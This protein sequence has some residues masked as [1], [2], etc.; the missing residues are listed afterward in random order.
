MLG[1]ACV[2]VYVGDVSECVVMLAF[3]VTRAINACH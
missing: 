3:G 1:D 2:D